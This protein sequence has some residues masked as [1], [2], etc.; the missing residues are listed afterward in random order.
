MPVKQ[1]QWG[2]EVPLVLSGVIWGSSF[3][4]SKIGVEHM[5]PVLFSFLR[6]FIATIS[7]LPILIFFKHFDR[8]VLTNK[9]IIAVSIMNA[10]AMAM[11]NISMTMTTSTNAVLLININVV[12]TALLAVVVLKEVLTRRTLIGL[13]IGMVGAFIITTNGD[14]GSLTGGNILGNVIALMAGVLWSFYVIYLAK[15][16]QAGAEQVSAT[17]VTIMYTMLA[18]VPLTLLVQPSYTVDSTA[19]GMAIY[20]GVICT[21]VAFL[22][23]NYGLRVLGATKASIILLTE[24]VFGMFFSMIFLN[25]IPTVAIAIGAGLVLFAVGLMSIKRKE[26]AAPRP[27]AHE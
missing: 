11:Q 27:D 8:K 16:M 7:I 4:T 9:Y 20:G 5:D 12:F 21:T 23:Y 2:V 13:T 1:K 15:A 22:L 18:L 10:V 3:V 19:L 14:I 26:K 6:Y 17:L 24:M 25:E